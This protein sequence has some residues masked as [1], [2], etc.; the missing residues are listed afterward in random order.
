[1]VKQQR[2]ISKWWWFWWWFWWWLFKLCVM[3]YISVYISTVIQNFWKRSYCSP[4]Y[5][6]PSSF[7]D[8]PLSPIRC[9]CNTWTLPNLN[10]QNLDCDN[11][12]DYYTNMIMTF[13]MMVPVILSAVEI[14]IWIIIPNIIVFS[15]TVKQHNQILKLCATFRII[16]NCY[17]K[18]SLLGKLGSS[19]DGVYLH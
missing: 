6:F 1:M 8:W 7:A 19:A 2:L 10:F 12:N 17:F 15:C 11:N 3:V 14:F 18:L 5:I 9:W 13:I 16:R 4:T